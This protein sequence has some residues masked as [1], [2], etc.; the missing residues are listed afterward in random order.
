[1]KGI[2]EMANRVDNIVDDLFASFEKEQVDHVF[3]RHGITDLD[4]RVLLLQKCMQ[5][6]DTSDSSEYMP[7]EDRYADELEIFVYGRWR[8]LI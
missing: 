2:V 7:P 4:E 1:M 8:F 3:S 5:V 6:T